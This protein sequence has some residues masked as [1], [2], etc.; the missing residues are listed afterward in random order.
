M[1][2]RLLV[3]AGAAAILACGMATTIYAAGAYTTDK[4]I[5]A[6]VEQKLSRYVFY[7]IFDDVQGTIR[8]GVVTLTGNVTAPYKATEIANLVK[9]VSGVREVDNKI[10]TLP[11]STFDDELRVKI[12]SRIYRD[13]MFWNYAIQPTPPIH[14]IV[15]HGHVTLTGVVN[16]EVERIA[17]ESIARGVDAVFGV[18]NKLQL[19]RELRESN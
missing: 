12:A 5:R 9:H 13:P 7:S 2:R 1:L 6:E 18:D 19:E 8:D 15:N 3:P 16:S 4:Q 14:I 17:A 11:V 10:N